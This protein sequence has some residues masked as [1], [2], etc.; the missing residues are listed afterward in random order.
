MANFVQASEYD[1]YM[2]AKFEW[3]DHYDL[4]TLKH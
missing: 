4:S 3:L 1:V 2:H